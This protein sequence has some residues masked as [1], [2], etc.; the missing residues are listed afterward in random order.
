MK[1]TTL[2]PRRRNDGSRVSKDEMNSIVTELQNHFGGL[3]REGTVIGHWVDSADGK[4][5][6]DESL[7]VCVACDN[8]RLE[9]ARQFVTEIGRRLG[10][11]A[12]FFE[13]QYYDGVQILEIDDK[14]D[15]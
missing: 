7:K 8:R 2:I 12:M 4:V 10:Q 3:T 5:Y 15:E 9:E 11:K 13:V 6:V 1:F 14:H